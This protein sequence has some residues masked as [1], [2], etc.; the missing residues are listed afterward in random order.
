MLVS[1]WT[2]DQFPAGT[3]PL[4][5]HY[6]DPVIFEF[7]VGGA[8]YFGLRHVL[9]LKPPPRST[10]SNGAPAIPC[11]PSRGDGTTL[12][13]SADNRAVS[14]RQ[15]SSALSLLPPMNCLPGIAWRAIFLK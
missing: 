13:P 8:L 5:H 14:A 11:R 1:A 9:R 4:L 7:G 10:P 3:V 12:A 6:G 15:R 2:A